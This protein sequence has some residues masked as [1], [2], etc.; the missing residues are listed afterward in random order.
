MIDDGQ[1]LITFSIYNYSCMG[2][3]VPEKVMM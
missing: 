3:Q 2:F 1:L